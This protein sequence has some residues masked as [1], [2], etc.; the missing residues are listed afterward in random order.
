M[1]SILEL[2]SIKD[3]KCQSNYTISIFAEHLNYNLKRHLNAL[4]FKGVSLSIK[5]IYY[6]LRELIRAGAYFG[7]RGYRV[8]SFDSTDLYLSS[9]F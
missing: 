4:R 1:Q 2:S 6:I 9:A 8:R 7:K 3:I 5:E